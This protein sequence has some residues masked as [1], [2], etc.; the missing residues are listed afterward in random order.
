[1]E[2]SAT[3]ELSIQITDFN[4]GRIFQRKGTIGNIVISGTYTGLLGVIEDRVLK[5]GTS[6]EVVSR[7]VVDP[8]LK[9]G[10]FLGELRGVTQGGWYNIQVRNSGNYAVS[11]RGSHK[12]AV[13]ILVACLGQSNKK[14][15]YYTGTDYNKH[16]LLRKHTDK[17]WTELGTRG[18]AAIAFGN[19]MI[20]RLDVPVG[21][22]DNTVNGS[23]MRKE[24]DWGTGYWRKKPG[25]IDKRYLSGISAVGGSVEQVIWIQGEADA[26][27]GTVT[28]AEYKTTLESYNTNQVRSDIGNGSTQANLP[29]LNVMMIKRLGGEDELHQAIRNAQ[30]YVAENVNDCYLA[31]TT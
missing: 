25:T 31:A 16:S 29:F 18:D 8:S 6:E 14:E 11:R 21:L 24:A 28:E 13:G 26:A 1:M 30:K 20:E 10:F 12:W 22:I 5:N 23:G 19:S 4:E 27:R 2:E 15:W 9:N 7:T 17:G 3:E